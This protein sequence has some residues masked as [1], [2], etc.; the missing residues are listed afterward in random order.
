MQ[1]KGWD[2]RSFRIGERLIARLPSE[3]H[4]VA[5]TEKERR[6]LPFLTPR[7]PLPIPHV[8][9]SFAA[10]ADFPRPW[11]VTE[12]IE[13]ETATDVTGDALTT[14]AGDLASFLHA[15]HGVDPAQGP[16]AG[17]H[18]FGR[19]GPLSFYDAEMRWA[20]PRQ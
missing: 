10:G 2:N 20:L 18:S 8:V 4:Y 11:S 7:L 17:A 13:G 19:G 5:G 12:W 6:V 16:P 14:L 1:H 9:A 3:D 15:L